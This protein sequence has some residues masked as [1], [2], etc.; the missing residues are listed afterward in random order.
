[1]SILIKNGHILEFDAHSERLY[2]SDILIDGNFITK[3]EKNIQVDQVDK[4]IWADNRLIMPGLNIAHAHSWAQLL[5]GVV[6]GGP[7]EIWILENI[8][9]PKGW[10]F[11]PHQI[12]LRTILGA[13]EMIQCGATAVW[14]DLLLTTDL[15][16]HIFNAYKDS[17]MRATITA[18]M[19]DKRHP[20][21]TLLLDKTLPPNLL[22]AL[23]HEKI[24]PP[25]D[26]M[27]I[28]E[29]IISKW[30]QYDDRLN[31]AISVNWVQGSS[32]ELMVRAAALSEK[33]H[34]PFVTHALE[35]KIQQV[36]GQEYYG[37]TIIRRI[38]DLGV[39]TP[40]SSI[41]HGVWVTD[42]DIALL[43]GAQ[44]GVLHNPSSNLILGSGIMPYRKYADAGVNIALGVDEGYQSQWNPF[45]MM[46]IAGLMHKITDPDSRNWPTS[47]EILMN[48]TYG[49]ARSE[50]IHHEVGKVAVG[51]KAD[52]ILLN[53]ELL[54]ADSL[55][56]ISAY[57]VYCESGN[58]VETSIINGKLVME[59]RKILTIDVDAVISEINSIMPGYFKE[60]KEYGTLALSNEIRP[61][62]EKIYQ[63]VFE[64]PTGL[65]RWVG[66]ERE[67]IQKRGI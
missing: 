21:R 34:L 48:A 45:E 1:M 35:T 63:K 58:S 29:K 16:D 50:L 36:T 40:R 59:D 26:W 18:A 25:D 28:S 49:G 23:S 30:H 65:N 32:D 62:M 19:Y 12:Y 14:D 9:P 55:E 22:D 61:Y 13:I 27:E 43:A 41:V 17:G 53:M 51:Q 4:V 67:W 15:Q 56:N 10:S 54:K 52:L 2:Q 37:K 11:T 5:K 3:I 44:A 6:E 46:R 64:T 57:L 47:K 31:L 24:I 33:Y 42:E 7:L 8:A 38:H 66:D 20:E 60:Q 39:L